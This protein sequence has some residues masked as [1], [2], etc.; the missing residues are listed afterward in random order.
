MIL[1]H[2]AGSGI[3]PGLIVSHMNTREESNL[4]SVLCY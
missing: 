1:A 2:E 4:Y 3:E